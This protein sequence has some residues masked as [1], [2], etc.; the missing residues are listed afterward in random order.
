VFIDRY[1][2][3]S[4][5][6]G[7]IWSRLGAIRRYSSW[8]SLSQYRVPERIDPEATEEEARRV[9]RKLNRES[10]QEKRQ[11]KAKLWNPELAIYSRD[12]EDEDIYSDE[13]GMY[14]PVDSDVT[15]SFMSEEE[16]DFEARRSSTGSRWSGDS[17]SA[18]EM[19]DISG[20]R[21]QCSL[22]DDAS[23]ALKWDDIVHGVQG[24]VEDGSKLER[25]DGAVPPTRDRWSRDE[26]DSE[27]EWS[28]PS[29]FSSDSG[30]DIQNKRSASVDSGLPSE[31]RSDE[32]PTCQQPR[33]K[34][35]STT[36]R[37]A[38]TMEDLVDLD[39]RQRSPRN[40]SA[41]PWEY[42]Y[43]SDADAQHTRKQHAL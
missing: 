11:A 20:H 39:I 7:I 1:T 19:E 25:E 21:G 3:D 15:M 40:A 9:K 28:T 30:Q 31:S 33:R 27:R 5:F 32:E 22:L 42:E 37:P 36:K 35:M 13:D 12:E 14:T 2:V 18:S 10:Q 8:E 4:V 41:A 6:Q 34:R 23:K 24:D 43:S 38:S 29:D 17:H 26:S 16:S